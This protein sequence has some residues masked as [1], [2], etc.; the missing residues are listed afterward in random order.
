[1]AWDFEGC[2]KGAK[3]KLFCI[4][5]PAQSSK[6]TAGWAPDRASLGLGGG[7]RFRD[8]REIGT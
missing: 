2:R 8:L 6:V 3:L 5:L 1:M 4:L 7:S